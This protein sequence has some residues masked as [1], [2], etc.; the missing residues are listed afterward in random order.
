MQQCTLGDF[1]HYHDGINN[2][3]VSN[4]HTIFY[5]D[6]EENSLFVTLRSFGLFF[7]NPIVSKHIFMENLFDI[8]NGII[9]RNLNIV[10]AT[11]SLDILCLYRVS[12]KLISKQ[13]QIRT[14]IFLLRTNWSSSQQ[15]FCG[16]FNKIAQ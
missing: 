16:P 2:V 4:E 8:E 11:C 6:I 13:E 15:V 14:T 10:V 5:F 9:N 3:S 12:E 1:I 7:T